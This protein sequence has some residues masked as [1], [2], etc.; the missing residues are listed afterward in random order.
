VVDFGALPPEIN[1]ALMYSGAGSSSLQAAASA[2]NG[3]AAELSSAAAGYDKVIT[4]LASD[5]W[6]GPASASMAG[7]AQ[8]Y[9]SWMSTT[10]A[11][12]E[13]AAAQARAAAAAYEQA[14]SA[15][16]PPPLVAANRALTSEAL[17]ANVFGQYTPMIAQLEAQYGEMWAQ[18]SSAMYS[19]AGQSAAAAQV[20]SFASPEVTTNPG[21]AAAQAAAVSSATGTSAATGSQSIL[22]QLTSSLPS[23]LQGLASP[24]AA[25]TTT[26]SPLQSIFS[27]LFGTSVLPTSL[28][29]LFNDYSPI[30]GVLYNTEGL[31]YFSVG[32]GNFGIQ[33]AKT[34]GVLGGGGGA[35]AGAAAGGGTGGL[36]GLGGMLGGGP[37]AAAG[38]GVSASM[39]EAGL[40]GDLAVPPN[41][42]GSTPLAAPHAPLAISHVHAAP[43]S[44]A[45]NMMG[46]VPFAGPGAGHMGGGAGPR[47]GFKPTVM[48]RPPF[49]G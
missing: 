18:D 44:G 39:G 12:A 48:S 45:G 27:L 14:F 24:I 16:V 37:A 30:A 5:E 33:M 47:Y 38:S 22:Q 15:T 40:L 6:M 13:Q 20:T 26:L 19:Y 42:V 2:W 35:A 4:E 49:A 43:E 9:V 34:L 8:P 1:S 46:G 21:G 3:L 23:S 25:D 36:G 41:W 11:Q 31:P 29:A 7:A 28:S 10:A 17:Q 32:M